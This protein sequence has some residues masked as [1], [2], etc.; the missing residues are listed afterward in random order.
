MSKIKVLDGLTVQKIAAGEVI[1]RPASI[2][3]ELVEN[4]IDAGSTQIVVETIDGGKSL[5]RVT[6]NGEGMDR[7]D[8]LLAFKRHS[9]SK[10][11][12]IDDLN[13]IM[14][15]GFRGEALSSICAVAL[16]EVIT[17]RVESEE[18]IKAIVLDGIVNDIMPIGAPTGT[19]MIIKNLFFNL[20][21]RKKFL[22]SN[23]TED[24]H[25]SDILT[26]LAIGNPGVSFKYIR[27]NRVIFNTNGSK[28]NINTIYELLGKDNTRDLIPLDIE[29]EDF[30]VIGYLSK[31]TLYRSNRAHQYLYVNGRYVVDYKISRTIENQYTSLIPI[32]KYPIYI[33]NISIDPKNIDVNIHPTKQ[34]IKFIGDTM[35]YEKLGMVIK[36]NL[37][38]V[39][40]IPKPVNKRM[41]EV[42]TPS[43]FEINK[44]ERV[45]KP[46]K[47]EDDKE[48]IIVFKDLS[49]VEIV[50][51][52]EALSKEV[53]I[54]NQTNKKDFKF[55][56]L[57]QI[58]IGF[59]TYIFA[60]DILNDK[61]FIIDQHAAHERVLYE[62][63]LNEYNNESIIVQQLLYPEI[64]ELNPTEYI[65]AKE[66]ID[67]FNKIGF[68]IDIFDEKSIIIRGV[69]MI[70]GKPNSKSLFIEVLD[71]IDVKIMHNHELKLEKIIK[72]ACTSAIKA[73]DSIKNMEVSSLFKQLDNCNQPFTCPHGRPTIIE[74]T[75]DELEKKFL[76][77]M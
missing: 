58:G 63:L 39:I 77:I 11:Y 27:D 13:T 46:Y 1:E 33:L 15:L 26:K 16:V 67:Y 49:H 45:D 6:D 62:R 34:E 4:S 36:R 66:N 17:R 29:T 74:I 55:S 61:L 23:S 75:K 22:K 37:N 24:T 12:S 59:K 68:E 14:T 69:P 21:V 54:K 57:K 25:I 18:G 76:R 8:V 7:E 5:I 72:L 3:K 51:E 44:T 28:D 10:L 42:R 19:T 20:P 35:I 38:T 47:L 41:E 30:K 31:N 65:N 73:G 9:T 53:E 40:N 32:N 60:E 64:V 56:A 71:K 70:F 48:S 2:V 43:I 52:D 50:K